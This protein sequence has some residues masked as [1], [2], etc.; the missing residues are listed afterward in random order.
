MENNFVTKR[1]LAEL[2]FYY[3]LDSVAHSHEDIEL[4]YVLYGSVELS[5]EGKLYSLAPGDILVINPYELHYSSLSAEL[6]VCR[7][8]ISYQ[9]M[10]KLL[11]KDKVS[12][13]C[14]PGDKGKSAYGR[15]K[16][17]IERILAQSVSEDSPEL[18]LVALN[19]QLAEE[20]AAGFLVADG[21]EEKEHSEDHRMEAIMEY[22]RAN[23]REPITLMSLSEAV[24]LSN[25][26][27]SKYIKKQFN[28]N[29]KDLLNSVRLNHAI[30]DLTHS[31][32]PIMKIAMDNGFA[33]ASA[34][35]R[36]FKNTFGV[37]PSEYRKTH[38]DKDRDGGEKASEK[39]DPD[40]QAK[41]KAFL[42]KTEIKRHNA[43]STIDIT[44]NVDA[45]AV[46]SKQLSRN[47][48][49][50]INVGTAYDL[51]RSDFQEQIL[52]LHEKV[53]FKYVRFWDV[54]SNE[55]RIDI[56]GN[57]RNINMSRLFLALD[58][59]VDNGLKPF[60]ELGFKPMRLHKNAQEAL[61]DLHRAD[62][63][64]STDEMR[65]FLEAVMKNLVRRY[66]E[67][68]V[69]SWYFEFW[70]REALR[71]DR[72]IQYFL[73]DEKP[74]SR[75]F[76]EF[77]AMA[78]GIRSVLPGAKIGGGGF[79]CQHYGEEGLRN[80]FLEWKK[81]P[82]KPDFVSLNCYP[83]KHH[84]ENGRFYEKKDSN[85]NFIRSNI[86]EAKA[87]I[88]E[89]GF[90]VKEFFV[91]EF[92]FTLSNRNL[93]NDSC[94]KAC[95]LMQTLSEC[96]NDADILAYWMASD[97]YAEYND[98]NDF[99]FGG[100]G[101][102]SKNGTPKPAFYTFEFLS[103]LHDNLVEKT[104]NCI[105]TKNGYD[106]WKLVC[107]N[108]K[109]YN[110]DYYSRE[111]DRIKADELDSICVDSRPVNL[112]I[113]IDN[114]PN[115]VYQVRTREINSRSGSIQAIW[116]SMNMESDLDRDDL[117]Y[118]RRMCTPRL[119]RESIVVTDGTLS[120][121]IKIRPSEIKYLHIVLKKN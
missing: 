111:E 108:F 110:R 93:T 76:D 40:V 4:L 119:M 5:A 19:Y 103:R 68:E 50:M 64:H 101:L 104:A 82:Q 46:S 29:Y 65:S 21:G 69:G 7:F 41:V 57:P 118:I 60:V 37:M 52:F 8:M 28:M 90:R 24:Y 26:Y 112:N 34:F 98:T 114:I 97:A 95:Q 62:T 55:L 11:K 109:P 85:L 115:G 106:S 100:V 22:I 25:A 53:G 9:T 107:H 75:Y 99:L 32:E 61:I 17:I 89:T 79:S 43:D 88:R 117:A 38:Q 102:L 51:T 35:N 6:L 15:L 36:I 44:M 12:F 42:E 80:I 71:Y 96:M 45:N 39:V 20:M 77:D 63:F 56:H 14:G 83:Y 92:N 81:H 67:D 78:E 113:H 33:S 84:T 16:T 54:F 86:D 72:G 49:K 30:E 105:I 2:D 120:Y 13:S 73:K 18:S 58:F 66:G 91:T 59:L 27:L 74:D 3:Q 121:Q 70:K 94:N 23:Y 31:G 48:S 87:V 116:Q 1:I 47:W 10:C